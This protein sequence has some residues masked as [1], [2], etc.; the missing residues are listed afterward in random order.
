[1]A[2]VAVLS[3]SALF[4]VACGGGDGGGLSGVTGVKANATASTSSDEEVTPEEDSSD[5]GDNSGSTT[6]S[7]SADDYASNVCNAVAKYASDIEELSN[8]DFDT[9]DPAAMKDMMDQMVP[10]FEGLAKDLGKIKPP[11]DVKDWHN[12]MVDA[13]NQAAD[14]MGQ[15]STALDKPLDE[16]MS[17]IADLSTQMTDMEDPF[18]LTDLPDEYQ[19]AFDENSDCQDLSSLDIF[20]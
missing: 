4:A 15:M 2:L 10:I 12:Q 19:T 17:E 6:V 11:S 7:K 14:I 16:A 9:E 3:L 20:Q 1:L 13:L 5:N 18:T 8:A